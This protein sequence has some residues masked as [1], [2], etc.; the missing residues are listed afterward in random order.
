MN[1]AW[2]FWEHQCPSDAYNIVLEKSEDVPKFTQSNFESM[3]LG[4]ARLLY[5][6]LSPIEYGMRHPKIFRELAKVRNTF[7][8]MAGITPDWAFFMDS[9]I[10]Y[11]KDL[12]AEIAMLLRED[13]LPHIAGD[14]VLRYQLIEDAAELHQTL[15]ATDQ[16]AVLLSIEGAHALG[17]GPL[18]SAQMED[19]DYQTQVLE[20]LMML[21]GSKP[22]FEK[23]EFLQTPIALMTLNHF[24]WNGLSGHAKT[25][26]QVEGYLMDQSEGLDAGITPFGQ[27]FIELMLDRAAGRRI[28]VD[29]KHMSVS[30]RKQYYAYLEELKLRG[31]TVPVVASH[32]GLAG[33]SWRIL[34]DSK[35]QKSSP[36]TPWLNQAPISMFDEDVQMVLESKGIMGLML[37]KY[38]AAGPQA[39]K[40]LDETRAGSMERRQTYIKLLVLNMMEIVD[41]A[42]SV[43][44]WDIISIGSDFDGMI[45][46]METYD[47]GFK[48]P[49][50]R[51]DLLAYFEQPTDL[52]DLYPKRKV[53]RYMYGLKASNIVDK[54]M[55]GNLLAFTERIYNTQLSARQAPQEAGARD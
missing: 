1:N 43:E 13:G 31:D 19:E 47:Q 36:T 49:S 29:V 37:D 50:L 2:E 52:W 51:S 46:A 54:V 12:K 48:L 11:F 3:H 21:K 18:S 27:R 6:S 34:E 39:I 17:E 33:E 45:N 5:V 32:V 14:R 10:D 35:L 41:V 28:L 23:G 20:H 53:Q 4:N 42:Q 24:M 22:M 38:R 30:S 16:I 55:G 15:A 8:C 9:K 26:G 7:A 40:E 25:F 44:A